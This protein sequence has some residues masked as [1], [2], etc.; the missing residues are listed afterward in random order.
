MLSPSDC[1]ETTVT[2]DRVQVDAKPSGVVDVQKSA[3]LSRFAVQKNPACV[4]PSKAV[5]ASIIHH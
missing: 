2:R 3:N 5:G 1:S 4:M